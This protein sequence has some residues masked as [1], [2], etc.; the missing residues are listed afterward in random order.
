MLET[1]Q[2]TR[3]NDMLFLFFVD[4]YYLAT[5]NCRLTK[6]YYYLILLEGRFLLEA[7]FKNEIFLQV[8][9]MVKDLTIDIQQKH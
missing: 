8:I 3:R 7:I 4:S 5:R 1:I 6:F 2:N 9:F